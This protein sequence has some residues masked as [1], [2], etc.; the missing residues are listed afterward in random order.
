MPGLF[1]VYAAYHT[2]VLARIISASGS[3]SFFAVV[4]ITVTMYFAAYLAEVFFDFEGFGKG[5]THK[6]EAVQ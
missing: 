2:D 1:E 4:L 6:A 3:R 5:W